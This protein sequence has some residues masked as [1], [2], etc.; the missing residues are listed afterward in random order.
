ML[1]TDMCLAFSE[2]EGPRGPGGTLDLL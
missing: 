1:N 2:M